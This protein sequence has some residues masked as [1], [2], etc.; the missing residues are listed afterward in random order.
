MY[1]SRSQL[2]V[3]EPKNAKP[4]TESNTIHFI[5][6]YF[7]WRDKTKKYQAGKLLYTE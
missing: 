7:F 5:I 6:K 2:K 1:H 3:I 4:I